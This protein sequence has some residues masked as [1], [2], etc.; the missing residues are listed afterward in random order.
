MKIK[1]GIQI[2]YITISNDFYNSS[3]NTQFIISLIVCNNSLNFIANLITALRSRLIRLIKI[4][5]V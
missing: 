1:H 2:V 3:I 4:F 5:K